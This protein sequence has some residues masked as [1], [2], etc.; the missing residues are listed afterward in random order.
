M[1]TAAIIISILAL[2]FTVGSFWW[3]N[4]RKGDLQV[5]PPRSY[6]ITSSDTALTLQLPFIFFNNGPTPIFVHNLRLVFTEVRPQESVVFQGTVKELGFPETPMKTAT[7]FPIRGLEVQL[8]IC[9]FM[10]P[11]S[12]LRLKAGIYPVELHAMLDDRS[13]WNTVSSFTL[14]IDEEEVPTMRT[15]ELRPRDNVSVI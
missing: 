8:I 14:N 7:Q 4:W 3:M 12:R 13:D 6:A 1:D 2:L 15:D 10:N 5:S 9:W 11:G